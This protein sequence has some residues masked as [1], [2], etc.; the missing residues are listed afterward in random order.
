MVPMTDIPRPRD[1]F[2]ASYAE[3]TPPWDIGRPQ[4]PFAALA[5][6]GAL[7]GRV[8]DAGCGTGEH[9]LMAAAAGHEAVGIDLSPRAV[10]LARAKSAE[11]GVAARFEVADACSLGELG[12][13]FT[14][15]FDCGLLHVLDDT[16]R[17]RY[18]AA[19]GEVVEPGGHLHLL[20]FSEREPGDWGPRRVTE[21][22][23]A[24]AFADGWNLASVTPAVIELTWNEAGAQAW[25]ADVERLGT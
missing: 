13:T 24:E 4:P 7:A 22:E 21:A 8:L 14:T 1:D 25:L 23:L 20:C 6:S 2:D 5:A 12:E 10:E 17:A 9:A 16:D 3:G 11:R 19:L 18:V 15:V